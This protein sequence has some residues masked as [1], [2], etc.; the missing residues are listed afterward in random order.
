MFGVF[1]HTY[2]KTLVLS[3]HLHFHLTIGYHHHP[4]QDRYIESSSIAS[5]FVCLVNE[6]MEKMIN[7]K[8]Q[9]PLFIFFF[10]VNQT[11]R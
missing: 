4:D 8:F 11:S 9:L 1:V 10:L 7:M 3:V 6:N 5:I 2:T